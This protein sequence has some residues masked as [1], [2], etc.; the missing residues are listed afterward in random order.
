MRIR[1]SRLASAVAAIAAVLALAVT[2]LVSRGVIDALL[3]IVIVAVLAGTLRRYARAVG[4]YRRSSALLRR[5]ADG[6]LVSAPAAGGVDGYR[7]GGAS[8][9]HPGRTPEPQVPDRT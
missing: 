8:A 7:A 1:N 2:L 4:L 6:G 5:H 9:G 3:M